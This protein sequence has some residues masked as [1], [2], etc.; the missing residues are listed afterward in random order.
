MGRDRKE[1]YCRF[2]DAKVKTVAAASATD[3]SPADRPISWTH[4]QRE[5]PTSRGDE[6]G[7]GG[8]LDRCYI[9]T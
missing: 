4:K 7:E 1:G 5:N 9:H 3:A 2:A 8:F 6:G